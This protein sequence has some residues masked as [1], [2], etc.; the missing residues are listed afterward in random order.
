MEYACEW[1]NT[2]DK[3][4]E[5]HPYQ[6]KGYTNFKKDRDDKQDVLKCSKVS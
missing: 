6:Q 2:A 5:E 3:L 4:W 1:K